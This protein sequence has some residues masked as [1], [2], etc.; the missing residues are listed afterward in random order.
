VRAEHELHR[1]LPERDLVALDAR[2]RVR[3]ALDSDDQPAAPVNGRPQPA[4]RDVHRGDDPAVMKGVGG[5]IADRH[6]VG[7]EQQLGLA[8]GPPV[9]LESDRAQTARRQWAQRPMVA[10]ALL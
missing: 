4:G 7:G 10:Q 5:R 6:L 2:P 9:R 1:F 8:V 3:V